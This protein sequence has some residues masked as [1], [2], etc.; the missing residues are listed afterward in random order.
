MLFESDSKRQAYSNVGMNFKITEVS[1][2][3]RVTPCAP[4]VNP[5]GWQKPAPNFNA[6]E[7]G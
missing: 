6:G 3:G 5:N 4:C 2:A 7:A 1:L